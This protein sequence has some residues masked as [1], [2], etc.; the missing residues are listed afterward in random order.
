MCSNWRKNID[1]KDATLEP[2]I[3]DNYTDATSIKESVRKRY[4]IY[5]QVH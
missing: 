4:R 3:F 2:Q 1:G 5:D